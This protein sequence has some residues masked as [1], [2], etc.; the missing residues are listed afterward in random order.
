MMGLFS[1]KKK[2]DFD[3]LFKE[4]YRSLN[5]VMMQAQNEMDGVVKESLIQNVVDR[6]DELLSLIDQGAHFEKAH[7]ESL[8]ASAVKELE[9]VMALNKES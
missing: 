9:K 6:Y 2:V 1:K 3:E 5:K 7:F 4:K 8:K